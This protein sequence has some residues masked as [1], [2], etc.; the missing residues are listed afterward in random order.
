MLPHKLKLI[1]NSMI[2]WK[3]STFNI[4]VWKCEKCQK[5]LIIDVKKSSRLYLNGLLGEEIEDGKG[6]IE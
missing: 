1:R 5:L 2:Y 3:G 4:E 6:C